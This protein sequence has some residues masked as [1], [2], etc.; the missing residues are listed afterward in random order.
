MIEIRE[1][2]DTHERDTGTWSFSVL[3][4]LS[5]LPGGVWYLDE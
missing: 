4:T 5:V 3:G 2:Q 1:R